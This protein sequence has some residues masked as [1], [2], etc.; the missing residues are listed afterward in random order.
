MRKL[1]KAI[2]RF[3]ALHPKLAIPGL[4]RYIVGAN[5]I[6]F[7][8]SLFA[9]DGTLNFLAMDAA[10][11]LHGEIWRVVTYI[12]LP[13]EYGLNNGIFLIIY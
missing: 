4:M 10:R 12:L 8:L 6:F 9:G 11:V 7:V 3:C 13:T 5:A 2:D 1:N